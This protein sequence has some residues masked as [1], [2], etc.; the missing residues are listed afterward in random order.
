MMNQISNILSKNQM[1]KPTIVLWFII[2]MCVSALMIQCSREVAKP[3]QVGD[4]A[5]NF[6][7]K[8]L[9]GEQVALRDLIQKGPALVVFFAT[10]CAPCKAEVPILNQIHEKYRDKG[11]T[12]VGISVEE[13]RDKVTAFSQ[14]NDLRYPVLLDP[15]GKVAK[16][17]GLI[18]VPMNL[19]LN[20]QGIV[21][22]KHSRIIDEE[23]TTMLEAIA[24][25]TGVASR[26][27]S[28]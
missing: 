6:S 23:M 3:P 13:K 15:D 5:P 20:Q 16:Q 14:K 8:S 17:Y 21:L 7:L 28:Q 24:E 9:T 26:A 10:W 12:V 22:I 1:S 27:E 4:R 19:V 18:A 11:L 25:E 2:L